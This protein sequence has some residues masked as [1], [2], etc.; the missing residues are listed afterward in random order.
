MDKY[1]ATHGTLLKRMTAFIL[2]ITLSLGTT[3]GRAAVHAIV[4]K[5]HLA[6]KF[7]KIGFKMLLFLT[8]LSLLFIIKS[9]LFK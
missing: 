9:Q 3:K 7:I 2:M 4:K 6:D 8:V 1:H 5:A